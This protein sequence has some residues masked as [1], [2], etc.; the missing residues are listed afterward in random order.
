MGVCYSCNGC[1]KCRTWM[2][3]LKGKC[4]MCDAPIAEDDTFCP[5]CGKPLP[6]PPG[7][8]QTKRIASQL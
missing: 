7:K 2:E 6:S 4:P 3:S 5:R 1:G 8:A